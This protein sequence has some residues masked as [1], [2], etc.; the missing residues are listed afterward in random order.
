MGN[1]DCAI[2]GEEQLRHG[3]AHDVGAADDHGIDA[4]KVAHGGL[5][6]HDTAGWCTCHQRILARA[7]AAHIHHMKT[8]HV[9]VGVD[10]VQNL[11]TIDMLGHRHLHQYSVYGG[12]SVE[13]VNQR[14]KI[15]F[16]CIG[17]QTV[18][19]RIHANFHSLSG[20]VGH[21]NPRC[22]IFANQYHS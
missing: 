1:G 12:I 2:F 21:I 19:P 17:G 6:Q 16:G 9:L 22:R 11:G 7:Q 10:G 18:L 13:F 8:I 14:Q 3:L 5:R 20:L 15:S 4:I